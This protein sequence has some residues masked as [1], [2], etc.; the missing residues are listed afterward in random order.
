MIATHVDTNHIHNHLVV[1]S[2]SCVDG[3]KLHQSADDLLATGKP[4]TKS[5]LPMG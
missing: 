4:T 1:N 3:K 2:V 5:V